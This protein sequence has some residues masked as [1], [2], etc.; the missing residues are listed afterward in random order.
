MWLSIASFS[1]LS[2]E[3]NDD[4]RLWFICDELPS[5]HKLPQL[6]ETIAEVRK[7]GGC[8]ILGMQSFA[9]LQKIYGP[10]AAAEIFDLLNTRFFFRSSSAEMAQ[11]VSNELGHEEVEQ[12]HDSYSYGA[13]TIRDGITIGTQRVTRLLVSLAEMMALPD[14]TAYMRV[15]LPVPI[16]KI[17]LTCQQRIALHLALFLAATPQ[18]KQK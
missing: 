12:R 10:A 13:N 7:F 9:Q 4:R 15:P 11:R 1:L 17:N 8:F 14:L 6:A 16:T 18:T 5:L 2:L 3:E